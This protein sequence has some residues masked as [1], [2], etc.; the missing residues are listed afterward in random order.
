MVSCNH[1]HIQQLLLYFSTLLN[2]KFYNPQIKIILYCSYCLPFYFPPLFLK[3]FVDGLCNGRLHQINVTYNQRCKCVS[4]VLV[5]P[6][7]L[8]VVYQTSKYFYS[9]RFTQTI[10][11]L[12][13]VCRHI[14]SFECTTQYTWLG[15]T[16]KTMFLL[17]QHLVQQTAPSEAGSPC[18]RPRRP[19]EEQ[20]YT[21]TLP[22][23]V[24]LDLVGGG[25]CQATAPE[26]LPQAKR[27]STHCTGG[28]IGFR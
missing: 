18:D 21:S 4:Q 8:E 5:E 7:I 12:R 17:R 24:V 3:T 1:N 19:R 26:C 14:L 10:S 15:T 2:G 16:H 23:N 11:S 27:S 6:P 9:V 13:Q 28:W 25:E 22:L 20:K